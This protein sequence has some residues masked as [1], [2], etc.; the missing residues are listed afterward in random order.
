[1]NTNEAKFAELQ[2]EWFTAR[3]QVHENVQHWED[4]FEELR[5]EEN[6]LRDEGRWIHGRDDFLGVLG[7]PRDELAHSRIIKWLLDPCA[8]HG[9]GTRV[10]AGV[11]QKVFGSSYHVPR[12]ERAVAD[13]EVSLVD[14][15]LDIVVDAPE[16][17]LVIENKVDADETGQCAYYAEHLRADARCILLSPDGREATATNKFKPMRYADLAEILQRVLAEV[18]IGASGRRVAEDYLQTLKREFS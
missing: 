6:K 11:I 2:K 1:M 5:E 18:A 7:W 15:R 12:L 9:L 4:R 3:R 8:R 14:G 10:L 13:C 17:Y 16:L